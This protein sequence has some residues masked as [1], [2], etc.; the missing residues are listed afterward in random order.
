VEM[1]DILLEAGG[2]I[3][4]RNRYGCVVLMVLSW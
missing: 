2:N 4:H 3:N 1:A